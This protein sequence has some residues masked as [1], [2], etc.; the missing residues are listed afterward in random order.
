MMTYQVYYQRFFGLVRPAEM[1]LGY[2]GFSH[3]RVTQLAARSLEDV[4]HRMQAE[5]WSPQGQA[6]ALIRRLHLSHT[7]LSVGDVVQDS[8]DNWWVCD[9]AGWRPLEPIQVEARPPL[10]LATQATHPVRLKI[11][12][13]PA[14]LPADAYRLEYFDGTAFT[15]L[16]TLAQLIEQRQ[17]WAVRIDLAGTVYETAADYKFYVGYAVSDGWPE[18]IISVLANSPAMARQ[19][20]TEELS[21]PGRGHYLTRW[22]QGGRR[23]KPKANKNG[24]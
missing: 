10:W 4:F 5:R 18:A 15:D 20:I 21:K 6:R 7:S 1:K 14:S 9:M 19:R 3:R 17:D 12:D 11:S 24:S 2:L 8:R 23:V 16:V 22:T 13:R